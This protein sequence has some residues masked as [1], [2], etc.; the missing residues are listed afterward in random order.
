LVGI[1][2]Y[3]LGKGKKEKLGEWKHFINI[4]NYILSNYYNNV[5]NNPLEIP[6]QPELVKI[7]MTFVFT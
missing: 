5:P 4:H 7:K 3:I 1:T 2:I 6:S